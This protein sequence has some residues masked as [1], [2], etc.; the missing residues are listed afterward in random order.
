MQSKDQILKH[1]LDNQLT[2]AAIRIFFASSNLSEASCCGIH[3]GAPDN[4]ISETRV[5][6]RHARYIVEVATDNSFLAVE[7]GHECS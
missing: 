7:V 3:D 4:S 1:N 6:R 5:N 2:I